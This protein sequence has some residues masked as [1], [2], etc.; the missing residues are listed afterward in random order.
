VYTKR[1][2]A[3]LKKVPGAKV[4]VKENCKHFIMYDEPKWMF[5][6]MAAVLK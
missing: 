1:I 6:Q 5:D 4:A 2:E 3:Q